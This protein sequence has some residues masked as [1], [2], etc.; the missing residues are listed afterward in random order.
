MD[1]PEMKQST[2]FP[3]RPTGRAVSPRLRILLNGILALFSLLG[4]N[5][6]YLAGIT[7][8]EWW[9]SGR[10]GTYQNFFY[11]FMFLGHLGLGLLLI[12]PVVVFGILHFR[13]S[14]NRPNRR[15]V[16]LGYSLFMAALL[17]LATGLGL[18]RLD[19]FEIRNPLARSWIYWA[20]VAAPLACIWLYILHR[21]TGPRLHWKMGFRWSG[22]V[23]VLVAAMMTWHRADPRLWH[24]RTPKDGDRYF[25]PSSA[26]TATGNFIPA[27]SLMNNDYCLECHSDSYAGWAHSAHRFSSFNNPFYLFSVNQTRQ[28]GLLRDGNVQGSRWCAGCHDPAP[29]FS[30]AFDD[31]QFDMLRHPTSQAGITCVACHSIVEVRSTRGNGDYVIEEP[32][33]YPWAFAPTNSFRF[34]LNKQLVKAKP[35]FHKQTFLKPLHK[36]AE[37]CSTC[38]KVGLPREVTHYKDFLRG[39]NHYDTYLLTGISGH[40]ARSFY[41]PPVGR[42]NCAA[43]HMPLVASDNFGARYLGTNEFRSIHD[44]LFP[45]ANTALPSG[46]GDTLTLDRELAFLSNCVRV[47]F[48]AIREGGRIDGSLLAPVRPNLPRLHPGQSYLIEAVV[49]NLSVGHPLTQGT[50]DSNEVWVEGEVTDV[51]SGEVIGNSGGMGRHREVDPWSHFINIHMLDRNGRRID[52]RNAQDIFVPLYNHQIPPSGSSVVHYRLTVPEGQR[53][54]IQVTLRVNYRKFDTIYV[55]YI[56][57][58]GYTNGA[59]FQV[60]NDLPVAVLASDMVVLPVEGGTELPPAWSN[61]TNGIPVW[62]RWN[63]F[64]IGLFNKGDKGSEKGELREA[65]FAF[66]TVERLGRS[67]GPLNLAR[68]F[69]KEGRLE[70]AVTALQRAGDSQR[71]G[72]PANRWTL[73]WLS[74]MVN[75]Q[76]GFLDQ[77]IQNFTS[78]LEDR[79]AE[80][81][82]RKFDFSKDYEIINEL[83][84]TLFE[85]AKR[86]RNS[87][88]EQRRWLEKA[89]QRF[90]ETLAIDSENVTAHYNLSLLYSQLGDAEKSSMHRQLHERYRVDDNARDHAISVA[91]LTSPAADHASQSIVIYDLQRTL[92]PLSSNRSATP[93]DRLAELKPSDH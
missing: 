67:D 59:P 81:E 18:M 45:G 12:V 82:R 42:E 27:A 89:V 74:G 43:C 51:V 11:Q 15:A 76:N 58:N 22:V 4:A 92:P 7:F 5:S 88:A 21:L 49:R 53:N 8:L 72:I 2:P 90:Q 33:H 24:V 65:E 86:E 85:R 73:A 6:V 31:P 28:E 54:P 14:W 68:I 44:H 35:A 40:S 38:H 61:Q 37:F 9:Q 20:H 19:G 60:T 75:K 79:D 70:E 50:A 17:L 62:Q 26:R 83:G 10:A 46:R 3:R 84:L 47:D 55:N 41:Y 56:H 25:A 64:G 57:G 69:V 32:V 71:F 48:F 91:R 80:L 63:D 66:S 34:Y 16:R 39:Q 36:T 93:P 29:F 52:R 30:G 87:P 13:R 78:V 1:N 77:A 23:V